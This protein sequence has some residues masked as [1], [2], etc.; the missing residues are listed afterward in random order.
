MKNICKTCGKEYEVK[1]NETLAYY[2]CK[3][4]RE[5]SAERRKKLGLLVDKKVEISSKQINVKGKYGELIKKRS[6]SYSLI[7]KILLKVS[8]NTPLLLQRCAELAETNLNI[9]EEIIKEVLAEKPELGE[10]KELEQVFMK[11]TGSNKIINDLITNPLPTFRY[12][13]CFYCG[14]PL[15]KSTE[16]CSDCNRKVVHC[17][18]CKLIINFGKNAGKCSL[19]ESSAHFE[20]L[21]EWLKTQGKCPTCMQ[22]LPLEGIVS[23]TTIKAK[24]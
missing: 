2:E 23:I 13:T 6:E 11:S 24:E 7:L 14:N 21:Q 5:K 12:C 16:I 8:E 22:K 4:C 1:E 9:T 20:H 15:D 18:V 10:Y 17:S 19:C 3:D